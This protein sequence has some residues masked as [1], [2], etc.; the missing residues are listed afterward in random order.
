MASLED[1]L[2]CF[3]IPKVK[4]TFLE[5]S[6]S[7]SSTLIKGYCFSQLA[8]NTRSLILLACNLCKLKSLEN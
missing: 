3:D 7:Q 4:R 8:A 2:G 6:N 1:N 5:H